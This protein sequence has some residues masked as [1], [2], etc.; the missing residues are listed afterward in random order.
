MIKDGIAKS[1]NR[2]FITVLSSLGIPE[3][4][5]K[6]AELLINSGLT[7][8]DRLLE[9]ADNDDAERLTAIHGIGERTAETIISELKRPEQRQRIEAL[10]AAGLKLEADQSE[11]SVSDGIFSGQNWCITGSFDNFKPRD[12]ALDEIKK[13]G[14]STVG[15]VTGKTTHLLCGRGGGSKRAKAE[16]LG[17]II[18]DEQEFM[19]L[20]G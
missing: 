13:R 6:A 7:S 20:I 11:L 16:K 5:K 3:L 2:P 17:V 19:T 10:R 9:T 18:V 4:G 8:V 12:A 1:L 15:T 14:G